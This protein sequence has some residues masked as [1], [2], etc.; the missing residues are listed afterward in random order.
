MANLGYSIPQGGSQEVIIPII[1]TV[2]VD[3]STALLPLIRSSEF[4]LKRR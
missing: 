4:D 2:A 3:F 1:E